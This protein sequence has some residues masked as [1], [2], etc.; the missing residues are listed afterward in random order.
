MG[1]KHKQTLGFCFEQHVKT[2]DVFLLE[3]LCIIKEH[4]WMFLHAILLFMYLVFVSQCQRS[5]AT[6][7]ERLLSVSLILLSCFVW[8]HSAVA[9]IMHLEGV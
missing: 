3:A 7:K 9:A 4:P 5:A 8:L 1:R 2:S 6:L